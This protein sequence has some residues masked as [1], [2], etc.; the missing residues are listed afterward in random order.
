M[1]ILQLPYAKRAVMDIANHLICRQNGVSCEPWRGDGAGDEVDSS[2]PQISVATTMDSRNGNMQNEA[3]RRPKNLEV[4]AN[5][6]V[7][8]TKTSRREEDEDRESDDGSLPCTPETDS[9]TDVSGSGDEAL[10]A[11]TRQL[12]SQIMVLFS[13]RSV[14]RRTEHKALQTMK[15]VVNDVLEKHR[16]A[17]NGKEM[18]EFITKT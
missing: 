7:A 5:G 8:T 13:G 1:S 11:D 15:R 3:P 2:S 4:K 18:L 14:A 9:D 12:M 10:E 6:F 16:Y 17:Y